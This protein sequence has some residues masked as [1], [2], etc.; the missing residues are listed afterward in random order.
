MRFSAVRSRAI[1]L[2]QAT[3]TLSVSPALPS[4]AYIIEVAQRAGF[5]FDEQAPGQ[6]RY[7]RVRV[8]AGEHA[9]TEDQRKQLTAFVYPVADELRLVIL[10][11]IQYA[12][13][14]VGQPLLQVAPWPRDVPAVGC[15]SHDNDGNVKEAARAML[16]AVKQAGIRTTWCTLFPCGYPRSPFDEIRAA[17]GEIALHYDAMKEGPDRQWGFDKLVKQLEGLTA[18]SGVIEP[19]ANQS[20]V[21]AIAR[22][23]PTVEGKAMPDGNV[24]LRI[25]LADGRTDLVLALDAENP[26]NLRPSRIDGVVQVPAWGLVTD[27]ELGLVRLN[28]G[29]VEHVAS[30]GGTFVEVRGQRFD[31]Q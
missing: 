11:A 29:Q 9:L 19:Y 20:A 15:V 27:A 21:K 31:A 8:L 24:A 1:L 10:R 18:E 22:L 4:N 16:E 5:F 12:A 30:C 28:A 14:T 3:F 2:S 7:N 26:L 17:G 13:R 6:A 23:A 25:D